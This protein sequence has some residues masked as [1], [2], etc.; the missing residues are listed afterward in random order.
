MK[1]FQRRELWLPTCSACNCHRLT[2]Y[3]E[4]PLEKQLALKLFVDPLF[5]S[6][7]AV[8]EVASTPGRA[9]LAVDESD[10]LLRVRE[11]LLRG[12]FAA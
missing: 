1:S 2:D 5:F 6:V 9:I 11:F 12:R 10:L 7:S 8:N 4:W 3:S